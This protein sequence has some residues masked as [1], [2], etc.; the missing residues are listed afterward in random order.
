MVWGGDTAV[1]ELA[2]RPMAGMGPGAL[3]AVTATLGEPVPGARARPFFELLRA[4][5]EYRLAE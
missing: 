5:L 1:Q 4:C 2:Q 3:T